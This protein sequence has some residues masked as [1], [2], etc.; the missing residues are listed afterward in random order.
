MFL[1]QLLINKEIVGVGK[2]QM[3]EN[4]VL[5]ICSESGGRTVLEKFKEPDSFQKL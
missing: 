5:G 2:G 3:N 4:G 1:M